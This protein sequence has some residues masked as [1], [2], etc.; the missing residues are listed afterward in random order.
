MIHAIHLKGLTGRGHANDA[1]HL[2]DTKTHRITRPES[3][4]SPVA[5]A[6]LHL[7]LSNNCCQYNLYPHC[8]AV[9]DPNAP[10]PSLCRAEHACGSV[11]TWGLCL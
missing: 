6:L 8:P 10:E 1:R 2:P 7:F 11:G 3:A 5:L 9:L 4:L